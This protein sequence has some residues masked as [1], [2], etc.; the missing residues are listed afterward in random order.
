MRGSREWGLVL[1]LGIT[2]PLGCAGQEATRRDAFLNSDGVRIR[3]VVRG[4]GPPVLLVHGF[5]ADLELSWA[6]TGIL[7][8]LA[9]RY[10]VIALDQRGHGASDKL[11]DPRAYGVHFVDDLVRLLDHLKIERAHVIGYSMGGQVTLN[12]VT[13]HPD[14]VRSAVLGGYGWRPGELGRP[15]FLSE[16]IQ[17]L[18]RAARGEI[19]VLRAMVGTDTLALPPPVVAAFNRNDPRALGAVLRGDSALRAITEQQLRSVTIPVLAVVGEGDEWARAEVERMAGVMKRLEV[20]V[21][22]GA[23]HLSTTVHPLFLSSIVRFLG[24]H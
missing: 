14:R 7:D 12:L 24:A 2:L 6:G 15:D 18:D 13:R 8:S 21:V 17:A 10:Q 22:P 20:T 1:A 11:H 19:S 9:A 16:R 4:S 3:Y 23:N 5:S